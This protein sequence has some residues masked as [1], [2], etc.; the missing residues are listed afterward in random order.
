M[1]HFAHACAFC[2]ETRRAARALL[3]RHGHRPDDTVPGGERRVIAHD[4]G[5]VPVADRGHVADRLVTKNGWAGGGAPTRHCV[6]V[7]AAHCGEIDAHQDI[8]RGEFG[9]VER[10]DVDAFV[11]PHCRPCQ[12]RSDLIHPEILSTA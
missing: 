9:N 10:L 1:P 3:T 6:Q 8:T 2:R 11:G 7:T 5:S 12:T 4:C